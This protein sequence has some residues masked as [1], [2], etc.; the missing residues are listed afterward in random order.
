MEVSP[1]AGAAA[2]VRQHEG[3][4]ETYRKEDWWAIW[5]GL[6]IVLVAWLFFAGGST[7]KW[8]A[9]TPRRWSSFAQLAAD[10]AQHA[11]QYAVQ[12]AAW[13][14]ILGVSMRA[15]GHRLAHFIPSFA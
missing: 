12:L 3:W 1:G 15:M 2:P 9:V 4:R 11:G 8:I 7:I 14:V 5:L 6:G 13:L 10:L